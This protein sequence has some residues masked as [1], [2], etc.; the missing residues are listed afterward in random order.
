MVGG[1]ALAV[2]LL[3]PVAAYQYRREGRF[4]AGDLVVMLGALVY[5]IALWTYTM[6]P[7]PSGDHECVGRQLTP[8]ATL[9]ELRPLRGEGWATIVHDPAFLQVALNFVLFLPLGY[10]VRRVLGRG[11]V[12]ATLVG[13]GTSLMIEVVQGSGL[14]FLY[15]CPYRVFDVDDLL[16]N[17]IGATVGSILAVVLVRPHD[18]PGEVPTRLTLG[19]RW[20]GM[21]CDAL[22][23]V[24][25]GSTAAVLYRAFML[26]GLDR[27]LDQIDDTLQIAFQWGTPALAQVLIVLVAGHTVGEWVVS[28]RTAPR[29]L[30]V[31]LARV[32]KLL[33][34]VG[35]FLAL[36]AVHTSW[37]SPAMFA[38]AL[39]TLLAPL[40]TRDR[41]GLSHLVADL[42]LHV[43]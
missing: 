25:I 9:R 4:R 7:L 34:G 5:G 23:V 18:G 16:V 32:V 37:S 20:M 2:L 30:P 39:L 11:F 3:I 38:F 10:Y 36:G 14:L 12:V 27:E 26:Y 19:R 33:A 31:P 8:G 35:P 13:L 42:D 29:R 40:L 17:T 21:V 15:S 6:L 43:E 24:L 22:F 28:L 1:G 41:R